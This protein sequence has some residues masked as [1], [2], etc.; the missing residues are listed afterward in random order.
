MAENKKLK[1]CREKL[2]SKQNKEKEYSIDVVEESEQK[3]IV[4]LD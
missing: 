3:N 1:K 2:R 4:E